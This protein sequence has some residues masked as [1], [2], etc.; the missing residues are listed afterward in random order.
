MPLWKPLCCLLVPRD[1]AFQ[2]ERTSKT[3]TTRA[4]YSILEERGGSTVRCDAW[5]RASY[6]AVAQPPPPTMLG[7]RRK[8]SS[9]SAASPSKDGAAAAVPSLPAASASTSHLPAHISG[10]STLSS[11]GYPYQQESPARGIGTRLTLDEGDGED[12]DSGDV[13]PNPRTRRS[14]SVSNINLGYG[15]HHPIV[16]AGSRCVL[17]L[18]LQ[19]R[20]GGCV[21]VTRG[22]E[23]KLT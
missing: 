4:S 23:L 15:H 11:G 9:T 17:A 21:N 19:R 20:R 14:S 2:S 5:L 22:E 3:S 8:Q 18:S 16:G 1:L 10:G 12:G 6:E 13:Y 7:R